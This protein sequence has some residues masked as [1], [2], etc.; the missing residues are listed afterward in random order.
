MSGLRIA[1][2]AAAAAARAAPRRLL[3][4]RVLRRFEG[5]DFAAPPGRQLDPL[6]L[7]WRECAR[8]T[9]T[10]RTRHGRDVALLLP[11]GSQLRHGDVVFDDGDVLI[12]VAVPQCEVW[13]VSAEHDPAALLA[14]AVEFGNLHAP[15]EVTSAGAL[16]ILPD[17]PAL[18]VLRRHGLS[19][20]AARG[21]FAPL[22]ATVGPAVTLA[23]G[24]RVVGTSG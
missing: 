11:R 6:E 12:V 20:Q 1:P 4:E 9:L 7:T 5:D 23:D 3:C 17:G 18:S 22:K 16:V 14:A 10:K 19:Y 13:V 15:V 8:R 21:R 24:F 2:A